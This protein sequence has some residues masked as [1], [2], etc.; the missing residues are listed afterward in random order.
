MYTRLISGFL[1]GLLLGLFAE[2]QEA[3]DTAI[4]IT[5]NLIQVDAV[6]TDSNR[7]HVTSLEAKDFEILQD[8]KPQKITQFAYIPIVPAQLTAVTAA[9][10]EKKTT[11]PTP[12]PPAVSG[13]RHVQRTIVLMVDDLGLS[14]ESMTQVRRAV[15][16]FVD[17]QMQP[18]DL[19]AIVRTGA[20]MGAL[21]QFTSNKRQLYAA[22][23]GVRYN[24]VARQGIQDLTADPERR[25]E[26]RLNEFRESIL[27]VGT[28]GAIE[29]VVNGLSELPGRKSVILFSDG[30]R[31]MTTEGGPIKMVGS[32]QRVLDSLRRLTDL[33]NRSSVVI[34]TIDPRGVASLGLTAADQLSSSPGGQGRDTLS[35]PA[36]TVD[37]L[38]RE[39]VVGQVSAALSK[40][41]QDFSNT[42]EGLNYLAHE[43]AGL[44][45]HNTNDISAALNQVLED[46]SGYYL[47]GYT[48]DASTF[49]EK[50]ARPLFHTITV[51]VKRRGIH[52]RTRTGFYGVPD[53]AAHPAHRTR[54]EQ[55]MAALTSPF[56]GG[57]IHLRLT[58]LFANSPTKGSFIDSLLYV[59]AR[60]LT[61]ADQ[62]DDWHTST[63]N[64]AVMTF[65]IDGDEVD[66]SD[67]TFN[68]R[69]HGGE[70]KHAIENGLIFSL[71]HTIKKAGAYQ[72]RCAV[73]DAASERVGS[74][75]QFIDVPDLSKGRLSLSGLL[76]SG[77]QPDK[78]EAHAEPQAGTDPLGSPAV[79]N[80]KPG[81]RLAWA[82][83]IMNAQIDFPT[84]LPRLCLQLRIF[85]DGKEVFSGKTLPVNVEEQV[86]LKRIF[87]GG[88]LQ[89]GAKMEPG[90]YVL[91]AVV[92]DNL[93]KEKVRTATQSMDF[94]VAP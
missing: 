85:H 44:F 57:G 91:Q 15:K 87:A 7:H 84:H 55:L 41:S 93:A 79:R 48:P 78:P 80:F 1:C 60:D 37:Q 72:L 53:Q 59:D 10:A 31:L 73:R 82:L 92:T 81:S 69:V 51:R 38:D 23:E 75:S 5:V 46:Q 8:A 66:R 34:Y 89:L 27:S 62:P 25:A 35:A 39:P 43:T 30:M 20:G 4:R 3:P 52:V 21:E 70:V 28:L 86:D 88:Q 64:V 94:E 33:C 18:G 63:L 19:V 83:S 45:V 6:V 12:T 9:L 56:N 68:I 13:P 26:E 32:N 76:V 74:A 61:F 67:S 90:E 65:D 49:D 50:A 77:P 14:F 17:Q 71:N 40:R 2:G 54:G 16:N 11:L 36:E 24:G 58:P 22:I 47:I 29:F 42:Q